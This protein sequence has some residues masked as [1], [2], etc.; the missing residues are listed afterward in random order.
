MLA[1][2]LLPIQTGVG[3]AIILSLLHG[4][5]TITRTRLIEMDRMPGTTV[6]WPASATIAGER[7]PGLLVAAFQAP[8]SFLNADLFRRDLAAADPIARDKS[9]GGFAPCHPA[10]QQLQTLRTVRTQKSLPYL[11]RRGAWIRLK[12]RRAPATRSFAAQNPAVFLRPHRPHGLHLLVGGVT[13]CDPPP[14]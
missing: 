14:V 1:V 5:W 7:V 6:W 4:A 3:L 12:E 10:D 8:L 11:L 13:G 2:V 9:R